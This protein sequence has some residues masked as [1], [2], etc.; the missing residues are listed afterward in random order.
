MFGTVSTCVLSLRGSLAASHGML[1]KTQSA[2]VY[3]IG[4]YLVEVEVDIGI[5]A[6]A[7][8]ERGGTVGQRGQ[9][10]P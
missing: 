6:D 8:L 7:G 1:S 2:S 4:A 9:G 10:E 5:R 3:G